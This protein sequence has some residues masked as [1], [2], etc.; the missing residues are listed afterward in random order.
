MQKY[1]TLELEQKVIKKVLLIILDGFG[2]RNDK[3]FNA[4]LTAKTPNWN[5][6]TTKYAFGTLDASG[7]AVGLP[8][9]QFG[10]SEVGHLN[11][12]A[13]RLIKQDI[14]RINDAIV[15]GEFFKNPV[16]LGA[17]NLL[18]TNNIHVLG[19]LSD[20]GV[21]SHIDH[22]I[23]LIKFL[24]QYNKINVKNIYLHMFLDGR[25]TPPK[26]A[27]IYLEKLEKIISK[28]SKVKIATISGRYYAMDRD[29]RYERI[30]LAFDAIVSGNFAEI[31]DQSKSATDV[32]NNA[33]LH[34]EVD[35][36]IKPCVIGDYSGF[37]DGDTV[38][39]TNFRADRAIQL[40]DAIISEDFEYFSRPKI[41]LTNFLTMT[42]YDEKFRAKVLFEP[43]AIK[44]TLG[45][46]ISNLGYLQLRIAETEKYPHITYFF[47][48]GQKEPY[49]NEDRILVN[50][51]REVAT[52][53]LKPEMSLPEV[54]EKLVVA[55]RQNKYELIV[56]NFANG[57]MV[58][59]S[60]NFNATIKAV[61]AI[62]VALGICIKTM[63]EIGGEVLVIADHGNCEQMF[64]FK[65]NQV[66]TQHTNNLVPC[67]YV[68]RSATIKP[69]GCLY[70]VAPT[71]LAIAGLEK[72][73][74]M[75]GNNI[76]SLLEDGDLH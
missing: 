67:L 53:D 17:I 22:I 1:N 36:F 44:N 40:T 70:D 12:G 47:N 29:R 60:G 56:T 51:P 26:S 21:H 6:Y 7:K 57:D 10:N 55:I 3:D 58:G 18:N 25:D 38:F 74:E 76:V 61:E 50:S 73:E 24:D 32:V 45:E 64:D 20:G 30:K 13:G 49:L 65:S 5:Y 2:I 66:H 48:G 69:N 9:G 71:V 4:V 43:I 14:A 75:T 15:S 28:C 72:P 62:D 31:K 46:Y 54:T 27:L 16:L 37:V 35:E 34:N 11:I 63:L 8:E 23:A 33:Y 41:K 42:Q 68:G 19:L 59:H 39:F 52:Y